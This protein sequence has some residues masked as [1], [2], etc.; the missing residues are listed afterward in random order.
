[1]ATPSRGKAAKSYETVGTTYD[2][3]RVLKPRA[4]ATHFTAAEVKL[5]IAKAMEELASSGRSGAPRSGN[6]LVEPRAQGDFAVKRD[7]AKR[8]SAVRDTQ[9][10]AIARAKELEPD[11]A[12]LVKR[13]RNTKNGKASKWRKA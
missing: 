8:A 1:M 2:G 12:P 3:V 4:K 11:K 9:I 5:A 10:E 7:N 13:V 6:I